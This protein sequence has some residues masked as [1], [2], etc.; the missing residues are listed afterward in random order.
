MTEPPRNPGA[1]KPETTGE[2]ARAAE[3]GLLG[4]FDRDITAPMRDFRD[5]DQEWRRLFSEL[6]GT[7]FLVIV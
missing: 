5:P 7:F 3:A 2:Q 1:D 6:Y 4:W